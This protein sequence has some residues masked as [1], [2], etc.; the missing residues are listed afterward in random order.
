LTNVAVNEELFF[1]I[2]NHSITV[3]DVDAIYVKPF[4]AETILISSGQTTNILLYAKPPYPNATIFMMVKH[5]A[6]GSGTFDNSMVAAVLE[7]QKPHGSS[8]ISFDKN[9]PLYKP[10]VC[11]HFY[12]MVGLR[13]RPCPKNQTCQGPNNTKFVATH[14]GSPLC[15]IHWE[16]QRRL[17]P[18]L[19]CRC[20]NSIQLHWSSAKQ[21]DGE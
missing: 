11:R 5:Y 1:S 13:M 14:D 17:H 12:F 2:I 7:Y 19:P 18:D 9:L 4:D 15:T 16:V 21:H 6:I 8:N 10:H 3:V 20:P